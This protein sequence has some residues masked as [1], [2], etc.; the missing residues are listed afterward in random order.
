[1]TENHFCNCAKQR[2]CKKYFQNTV[3]KNF[4]CGI[5]SSV[6]TEA[7]GNT[8][9]GAPINSNDGGKVYEKKNF[10]KRSGPCSCVGHADFSSGM[11]RRQFR[12]QRGL[13]GVRHSVNGTGTK[14]ESGFLASVDRR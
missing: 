1:M 14:N 6:G 12:K 5:L 3:E 13:R 2:F 10:Q 8:Y 7:P 4:F 11:L 9:P